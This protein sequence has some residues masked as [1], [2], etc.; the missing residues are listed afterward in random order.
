MKK[1]NNQTVYTAI[2]LS[3]FLI[4]FSCKNE[5]MD[6]NNQ[7]QE[8]KNFS[9]SDAQMQL[10]N[11]KVSEAKE[12]MLGRQLLLTGVLKVDEQSAEIL[13]CGISGRILKLF[14]KNSGDFIREGD[15]IFELYSEDL[16]EL[17]KDFLIMQ[18]D[19]WDVVA[20]SQYQALYNKMLLIGMLPSQI[21]QLSKNKNASSVVKIHSTGSGIIRSVNVFE[22]QY[23]TSGQTLFELADDNSLVAEAIVYPDELKFLKIGMPVNISIPI[24]GDTS[25]KS[26]ISFINPAYEAG[27]NVTLIRSNINN[28]GK[29][30]HPGMPA[31]FGVQINR[32]AGIVIPSSAVLTDKKGSM[33]WVQR[34]DGSFMRKRVVTG[35]QSA[36]SVMITSGL[37]PL[38]KVVVSGAYLLNSE[39]LL[40]SDAFKN[41]GV[42]L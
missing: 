3:M 22:G 20:K 18:S 39:A 21:D 38:E 40:N 26:V 19:T 15:S 24:Q 7:G 37:S 4:L 8:K 10:G 17:Q 33:V 23:I 28:P 25:I 32:S 34:D 13:S 27:S 2:I 31:L 11:I 35:I 30:L 16:L 5:E 9:L 6:M 41:T 36:D 29:L 14:Y 42:E 12:G 1:I